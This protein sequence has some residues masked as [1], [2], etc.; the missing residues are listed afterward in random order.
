M[1]VSALVK[2][3]K[4]TTPELCKIVDAFLLFTMMTGVI[5]F[6]CLI[7]LGTYP[8]NAFLSG[9]GCSCGM[10]V[11]GGTLIANSAN[12]RIQLDPKT[13][14]IQSNERAF[15]DFAFSSMVLFAFVVC[16]IG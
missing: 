13:K 3:Y 6:L 14:A 11:N 4:N 16:F 1:N 12:L 9:L 15:A 8:Y 10:F 5:Q 7:I 2:S